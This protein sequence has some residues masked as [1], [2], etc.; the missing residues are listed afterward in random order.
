MPG[1]GHIA[2]DHIYRPFNRRFLGVSI[3][4]LPILGLQSTDAGHPNLSRRARPASIGVAQKFLDICLNLR[5]EKIALDSRHAL[6]GLGRDDI[7]AQY[8]A[9][10]L[11]AVHSH[12]ASH[13]PA[14]GGCLYMLIGAR[15]KV[16]LLAT[17]SLA[18]TPSESHW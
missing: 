16:D 15:E 14:T 18:H 1:C 11:S 10:G 4:C 6:R 8:S 9:I 17:K 2:E 3:G 12:L 13:Q 5:G 7:D